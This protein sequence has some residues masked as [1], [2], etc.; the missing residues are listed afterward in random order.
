MAGDEKGHAVAGEPAE[1]VP[2]VA[3]QDGVEPDG[4][5]VE[6]EQLGR[7]DEGRCEADAAALPAREG[8]GAR[9]DV[10]RQ[11]DAG[12]RLPAAPRGSRTPTSRARWATFSPTVRSP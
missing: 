1:E 12:D 9:V 10:A 2:Q 5:L 8:I 3:P 11:V 7:T 4:R 6:H